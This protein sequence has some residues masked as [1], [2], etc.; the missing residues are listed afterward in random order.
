MID[1]GLKW[2]FSKSINAGGHGVNDGYTDLFP[3][4][5]YSNLIRESIQNS[6]DAHEE[7]NPNPVRVEYTIRDFFT[8]DF[9]N[10]T[11]LREHIKVCAEVHTTS[12]KYKDMLGYIAEPMMTVLEIAD[13]N[14]TG[15]DYDGET[16]SGKFRK[17]VRYA[18]D[19][20]SNDGA[21]G[22]H[23]YGKITYFHLSDIKT[24]FVSS[25]FHE[26]LCCTFE[27]VARL[28]T[29][30][31]GKIKETFGDTGFFDLGYGDPIQEF[32]SDKN[33]DGSYIFKNIPKEFQ[34][35]EP[36]TTVSILFSNVRREGIDK[37]FKMC[38]EAVLRSFFATIEE[39]L[40]EVRIAFDQE[41]NIEIKKSNLEN[42]FREEF[43]TSTVDNVKNKVFDR[44]NPHPY[45]QAYKYGASYIVPEGTPV[46]E[47]VVHCVGRTYLKIEERLPILG[48]VGFYLNVSQ[49]GN[50]II[51]FARNPRM[52]VYVQ[53]S[54]SKQKKGYSAVF[55]CEDEEGNKLLRRME[56]A[57]H[58]TW[59]MAQ[60]KRDSRSKEDVKQAE[61]IEQEMH[62][63]IEK[64]LN[65]IIF[66]IDN[67][68][69]EDIQLEDIT[70]PIIS[71]DETMNPLLGVLISKQGSDEN[72]KGAPVDVNV[73]QG[74]TATSKVFVGQAQTIEKKKVK[75]ATKKSE[76]TSGGGRSDGGGGGNSTSGAQELEEDSEGYFKLVRRKLKLNSYRVISD[77]K[78]DGSIDFTLIVNSP[79]DVERAYLRLSPVGETADDG[80]IQIASTSEGKVIG[81]EISGLSLKEGKNEILFSL[82][83]EGEYTF[84]LSAEQDV[85]VKI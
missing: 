79:R 71:D 59:S 65:Q 34:R 78:E 33:P 13:Y 17:F 22:S 45:W 12:A 51:I 39:G 35:N 55:V 76:Y 29:H 24:I 10:L 67:S 80:S 28:A 31:T 30:P 50:D 81:N 21:G 85:K 58:R 68:D 37:V 73:G 74:T 23:G 6:L 82:N 46:E 57:A 18:G 66:P 26:N 44:L 48:K 42:I 53:K 61:D 32:A 14:T 62:T 63:F 47:A 83:D 8:A 60:L 2:Y 11:T 7:G 69:E 9:A 77:T 5:P 49:Y 56:D 41:H 15:M 64:C 84:T 36:G 40:L 43:F 16:D 75:K 19:P 25:M 52:M 20:N 54:R 4:E 38:V 27:G 70:M 1:E 3:G 72:Q